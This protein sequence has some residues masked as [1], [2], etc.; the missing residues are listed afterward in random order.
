MATESSEQ[1]GIRLMFENDRVKVWD[2]HLAPGEDFP[3][4][5]HRLDYFLIVES[6][7]LLRFDDPDQP[8]GHRDV[9]YVDD[10]VLFREVGPA[11]KVDRHLTN[12]GSRRHRNFI[13]ELK[14]S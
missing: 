4:H 10:A 13:V 7:G 6:G 1:V 14:R 9:Q 12:I 8:E 3:E 2:L 11:G 5:V